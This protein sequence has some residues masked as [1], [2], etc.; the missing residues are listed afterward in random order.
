VAL[1]IL[2]VARLERNT[3]SNQMEDLDKSISH[4][5]EAIL[6]PPRSWIDHGPMFLRTLFFLAG[7]LVQ[8]SMVSKLPE[9]AIYAA[10]Y[11][12]YLRDR[13]HASSACQRHGVT[14]ILVVS[15]ALQVELKAG[16]VLQIIEEMAAV[17]HELLT[18]PD[19]SDIYIIGSITLFAEVALSK[20]SW[21]FQFPDQ[22]L[23]QIIECLRLARTRKPE[24]RNAQ[25]A[26]VRSLSRRY[27]ATFA[28][29][30]YEEAVSILGEMITY[31]SPRDEVAVN[32]QHYVTLAIYR[33]I[34]HQTPEYWEEA[35]YRSRAFL[36]AP[37]VDNFV[38][39]LVGS[40]LASSAE[41]RFHYFGSANDLGASCSLSR[42]SSLPVPDDNPELEKPVWIVKRI[43]L[44]EGLLSGIINDDITDIE[45]AIEA[46]RTTL[47]SFSPRDPIAPLLEKFGQILFEA[48]Q[49]TKKIEYL[50]E[51]ITTYRQVLGYPIDHLRF[52]TLK[53]LFLALLT[54]FRN[55]LHRTQD[56]EEALDALSQGVND[57]HAD[58]PG[59]FRFNLH[60]FGHTLREVSDTPPPPQRTRLL[61]H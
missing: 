15:L 29:D 26:L 21:P 54:R 43:E 61:C 1:H 27:P 17:F 22:V 6:L 28:N 39:S 38:H 36:S 47:A 18:S 57:R 33:A 52:S 44:L 9:N 40:V 4:C 34:T 35:I 3:L 50:N 12:R 46:G 16:D 23:S 11:L 25:L 48:F 41:Q 19:A 56:F 51:S 59:R 37:S 58:S 20:I 2:A 60:A 30:D 32:V 13:P 42:P 31:S 7:A 55:F 10:K 49:R 24:L 5:T 14:K 45:K 8:R 53:H